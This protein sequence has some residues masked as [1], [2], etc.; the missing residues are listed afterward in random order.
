MSTATTIVSCARRESYVQFDAEYVPLIAGGRVGQYA[1][2]IYPVR[3]DSHGTHELAHVDT[4]GAM[5]QTQTIIHGEDKGHKWTVRVSRHRGAAPTQPYF[6]SGAYS[7]PLEFCPYDSDGVAASTVVMLH[8]FATTYT[9]TGQQCWTH[10]GTAMVPVATI[11]RH[12]EDGA[13]ENRVEFVH[14]RDNDGGARPQ[15]KG[16]LKLSNFSAV[17]VRL[18][19]PTPDDI[20][21]SRE[22]MDAASKQ[23]T[24]VINRGML[25]FFGE[26]YVGDERRLP[27]DRFVVHSG[28]GAFLTR[29]TRPFL[30]RFHVPVFN[31]ERS[32][33][34]SSAYSMLMPAGEFDLAYMERLVEIALRRSS[35]TAAR[36]KELGE[37]TLSGGAQRYELYAFAS[38]AVRAMTVFALSQCYLDDFLNRN[39]PGQKWRDNLV[40]GDEDFKI[41]RLCGGDDCEGVALEIHMHI[42]QLCQSDSLVI[43]SP[44]LNLV[45]RFFRLF[46]PTLTLGCVTNKKLTAEEL[47]QNTVMAHTFSTL[48]PFWHFYSASSEHARAFLKRSHFYTSRSAELNQHRETDLMPLIG[49]GTAPI[50]PAMQPVVSYYVN[51]AVKETRAVAS[52]DR[53]RELTRLIIEVLDRWKQRNLSI[54]SFGAPDTAR[55]QRSPFYQY[56]VSFMTPEFADL[57]TFDWSFVYN[58]DDAQRRT[59]GV[60]FADVVDAAPSVGVMAHLDITQEEARVIDT[61]LMD[62]QPIPVLRLAGETRPSGA[63]QS[64][65]KQLA[66]LFKSLPPLPGTELHPRQTFLTIRARDMDE[67]TVGALRDIAALPMVRAFECK[68]WHLNKAVD[69]SGIDNVILDVYVGF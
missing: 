1:A 28:V 45:R 59:V 29:A 57:R 37:L 24:A 69:G 47:D 40:E 13:S 19:E 54:E 30:R 35:L 27:N 9:E 56:P 58:R 23:M 14:N 36:A 18:C 16:K 38:F 20:D 52:A 11:L 34:P 64:Y 26:E 5:V 49:E 4:C 62:E 60:A 21:I 17:N 53:R 33:V 7:R 67:Q 55:A 51:D 61:I 48:V 8:A 22:R 65:G 2:E 42:R 25:A 50:D 15:I 46:V 43:A 41:C 32:C 3:I 12:A 44:L 31:T 6:Q 66:A 39:T 63:Q 10:A 68:W